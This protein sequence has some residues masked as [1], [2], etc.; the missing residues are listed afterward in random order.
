[1]EVDLKRRG[2]EMK[3]KVVEKGVVFDFV[4]DNVLLVYLYFGENFW[5]LDIVEYVKYMKVE[6]LWDGE[7][8]KKDL[9][10]DNLG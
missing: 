7:N 4:L 10:L 3:V 9:V 8:G 2:G 1:M 5:L 6:F